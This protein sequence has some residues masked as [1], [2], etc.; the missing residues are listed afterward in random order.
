MSS[1]KDA[2]THDTH[3]DDQRR[4]ALITGSTDGIGLHTACSL[5]ASGHGVIV[6]GRSKDRVDEAV[7]RVSSVSAQ[8]GGVVASYVRDFDSLD[9]VRAL[10]RDVLDNHPRL[11]VLDNNAGVF[12]PKRFVT[13]DGFERTFQVNVI[14]PYLLTGLLLPRLATTAAAATAAT[15]T[16]AD[17]SSNVVGGGR[18]V[19]ILNVASISQTAGV[20]WDNLQAEK[21]FSDHNSYCHSKTCMKLFSFELHE[22]IRRAAATAAAA[23]AAVGSEDGATIEAGASSNSPSSSWAAALGEIVVLTCDPGTVN[24]KMLLAG[25]GPCGIETYQANDQFKL[26]TEPRFREDGARG[27]YHV[28]LSMRQRPEGEGDATSS[29]RKKLWEVLE[30]MTGFVYPI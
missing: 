15:A 8:G 7:A 19:R 22:R 18:D 30:Q 4:I 17:T 6:H 12:E 5:A 28:N 1:S 10:A 14:T 9:E 26:M 2:T 23:A 3:R 11:D 16:Q 25:W 20:Q 29:E 21:S 13:G 24:T 27:G